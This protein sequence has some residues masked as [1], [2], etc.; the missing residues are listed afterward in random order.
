MSDQQ[1]L[2]PT[3]TNFVDLLEYRATHTPNQTAY[4][5]L[6]EGETETARITYAELQQ[7]TQL[8]ATH[9]TTK[10]NPGDRALLLYSSG[11][12]FIITFFAC[13]RAYIIA[14]PIYPP[15]RNQSLTRLQ[16]IA[17][18]S[19]PTLALTTQKTLT[20]ITKNWETPPLD[21]DINWIATDHPA[22]LSGVEG[23]GDDHSRRLSGAE[24]FLQYTSGSTGTPKGV[25]VTHTN[26]IHNSRNIY[27][28]FNSHP[29]HIGVSWL[30]FHHDMGLIGGVLQS[31]YG[32][33]T[34]ILM[35]PVAFLQKP[36]RWLQAISH[37][38]ACTSG[39]PNFAYD[40][41]VQTA[42][43]E[44]IAQLDLSYWTLAFTGAE[45]IRPETLEKFT[46]TFSD[47]GFQRKTFYPCYGMA[48]TTL[49]VT[50]GNRTEEPITYTAN[51]SALESNKVVTST[52]KEKLSETKTLIGCGHTWLDQQVKIV[53]P[54]T[55][56]PCKPEEIGEI[57]VSGSSVTKGYWQKP[58][59]TKETFQAYLRDTKEGPYLRTGDL[60][61]LQSEELF[62]TGRLKDI[63][64][65]RGRNYYPQDIEL[66]VETAHE[67][68]QPNGCAAFSIEKN[69]TEQL[70]VIQEVKRPYLRK[71]SDKQ[72]KKEIILSIRRA[73]SEAHELQPHAIVLLKP[74]HLPKTSSGKV[75]RKQCKQDFIEEN[76]EAIALWER[77]LQSN[78]PEPNPTFAVDLNPLSPADRITAVETWLTQRIAQYA[79]LSPAEINRQEPLAS[80]GLSSLQVVEISTE[81]EA[82]LNQSILPTI[83]YDFPTIATL[84]QQLI[85][86][87]Q[88]P[89]AETTPEPQK[90]SPSK[91]TTEDEIAVVGIGCRFPGAPTVQAFWQLLQQGQDAITEI[92]LS[93]WDT[94]EVPVQNI[95][96]HGG[97]L[98][99]IDQFD[100]K[101]FGISPREATHMDPQQR[102]LLEVCWE[103]LENAGI[104]AD[105]LEGSQSGI[106]LGISNGDYSRLQAT[107]LNTEV[108]YGTGNA[109][110][111]TANR[112]S[113]FFNWHGPSYA[114]D[115]ACS[116]S[117]VA[118]HQACNSL[119]QKE[120]N[121]ALAG[122]I[123]LILSPQLTVTFSQAQMMA[124]DGRCKTFDANADGYVRSE[125]CGII[126]LKRLSDALADNNHILGVIK[127]S[128]INQDGRSNGLTAPNGVAQQTVIRQALAN[129]NISAEQIDYIE[130]HGTGTALGDPIEVNALK[131]VFSQKRG[132][133]IPHWLGSVKTNIG[134]LES[135]AGIAGV[136][137]VLLS[138]QNEVIPPH[139]HL[140]KVNPYIQI[141]NLPLSIPTKQQAWK[142]ST[143]PRLAGVSSFGFGGT[144]AHIIISDRPNRTVQ[145]FNTKKPQPTH[146]F[147]LSANSEQ[148]L[149]ELVSRYQD[150]LESNSHIPIEEIC[151]GVNVGRSHLTH[152]LAITTPSTQQLQTQLQTLSNNPTVIK[153]K[154]PN[155]KPPKIAFLFTGQGS[156]YFSM[157]KELYNT[158]PTFRKTLSRCAEILTQYNINLLEVLYQQNNNQLNQTAY[159]QPVL[160]VLEYALAKLWQSWGIKPD[161]VLGH[162]VG[163][164]AAACIA[165]VF[166]LEEG[167]K[168]IAERGRLMQALPTG[169]KMLSLLATQTQAQTII[170]PYKES[171]S[172]AAINGPESIVISGEGKA[173]SEIIPQL[174]QQQIKHKK[175]TVSHAFHS[176]LMSPIV[177]D[178]A[179]LANSIT[180]Q[181]SSIPFISCLTGE[182]IA[183]K[184]ATANY[185]I[186]HIQQPVQFAP[187]VQTLH[188]KEAHIL[189]EVGPKPLLLGMAKQCQPEANVQYLPSLRPNQRDWQQLLTTLSHLYIQG[190][191][192]N[193]K[194][195][196]PNQI[197]K[198][199]L[200]P[201]YPF[202]RRRYWIEPSTPSTHQPHSQI[203]QTVASKNSPAST[204]KHLS[205]TALYPSRHPLL[206]Q[207]LSSPLIQFQSQISAHFPNYLT[208]HKVFSQT[209]FPA[210]AYLEIALTA[211]ASQNEVNTSLTLSDVNI[212]RGLILPE[213]L[214]EE[215]EITL[216]TILTPKENKTYQFQIFSLEQT[217]AQ[218][219]AQWIEHTT[220]IVKTTELAT[221]TPVD[222]ESYKSNF[223]EVVPVESFYRKLRDRTLEYGPTFQTI[224][225]LWRAPHQ[226]LAQITLSK[227][228]EADSSEPETYQIHPTLLDGCFQILAAAIDNTETQYIYL[229][230]G[231]EQL[232]L[233]APIPSQV[234]AI[235]TLLQPKDSST[236]QLLGNI[237]ITDSAGNLLAEVKGLILKQTNKDLLLRILQPAAPPTLYT[238]SWEKSPLR[239]QPAPI[240]SENWL[241]FLPQQPISQTLTAALQAQGHNCIQVHRSD[242]YQQIDNQHYQL[243][244][245]QPADYQQLIQSLANTIIKG[246]V[247]LQSIAT[248]NPSQEVLYLTQALIQS[249]TTT[250]LW[251][252]TRGVQLIESNSNPIQLSTIQQSTLHGL[253]RVIN[254][255]HPE[256]NCRSLDLDPNA[257]D[258]Q[259]LI[260]E[261]LSPDTENQ[262][263]HRNSDRYIAHLT[264]YHP[265]TQTNLLPIPRSSSFQL[266][267]KEYGLIDNLTLQPTQRRSPGP[268]DV[269][270]QV[271]AAGLNFRDV[272]NVLGLLKDYYAQNLGIT[273]ANQLTFGFECAGT[274]VSK[275]SQVSHL[276]IGDEVIATMLTDGVSR[277]VTTRSEFVIPKPTHIS[278]AEA[279]TL[280]LAFLT[281]YYGLHHLTQ[282]KPG[283]KI[284]IHAAAGGVGQ[285]AVQIA[286]KAGAEIFATASPSKWDFLKKQGISH[287]MN[288][289]TLAFAEEIKQA[290]NNKGVDVILNSLNGEYIAKSFE[291]LAENGRFIELGKIG[292]WKRSKVQETYP[293]AHYYPFDLGEV[294]KENPAIIHNLWTKLSTHFNQQH[295]QSLPSKSF[296]VQQSTQAFR[297]IQQA[298]HIGKVVL[299]LPVSSSQNIISPTSNYLVTGGLGAL[300]LQIAQWLTNQ[301]AQQVTLVGR[302]N[303]SPAAETKIAQM[304]AAGTNIV[305]LK[306]DISKERVVA[307]IIQQLKTETHLPLK[308]LIHTAGVLEDGLLSQLSWTQFENVMAPKARGTWHLHQHTQSLS[309]DFFVCFSSIASLIGSPGQAN[310]AAANTF[311]DTLMQHRR[312]S[313]LPGLSI[314]WGPWSNAGMAAQL[315]STTQK[316]MR[317]RG[318]N[319]IDPEA[320]L[321]I[322]KDLLTTSITN[323]STDTPAQVGAF[324]INWNKFIAQLPSRVSLPLLKQLKEQ[325]QTDNSSLQSD[326]LQGLEQLKQLPVAERRQRLMHQIQAEIADVLGYNDPKEIA[327]DQP[328][329]DLGVDSLMA[330]ELANQLEHNLGPTIPASFLFEHPTLQGLVNYL[331]EQ[332]S[333]VE[334]D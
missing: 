52:R 22:T 307:D 271:A 109:F 170:E 175:L 35:P 173:I 185:W 259:Q 314:N 253:S 283:D 247:Y 297:Y 301:G 325:I 37:Y 132:N 248:S 6:E 316:R 62:I 151:F 157:G 8:L 264:H 298:K 9:L 57:W 150:F 141:E 255:E 179:A 153:G 58:K 251:L 20:D 286:Q 209:I 56:L 169:G 11:L 212:Q 55:F 161:T 303:P 231:I 309:L 195:L 184:I 43:P 10:A 128:A 127:G 140:K 191:K 287:I 155:H 268:H 133:D 130:A 80:Y 324:S 160:F 320:A 120:C 48:E 106:F 15:R 124:A 250:S 97:F 108:Y 102:L 226:A 192:I 216:Q 85:L 315:D 269:E 30:P 1:T 318:I 224:T 61:F 284:L 39:G 241:L 229:P 147:T 63:I 198:G 223:L 181:T 330:V 105:Q 182:P 332:L 188:Q 110:S 230:S 54:E 322:L 12:D 245:T 41:C 219:E 289:R 200:L 5:F 240:L 266:K 242:Q 13:L 329:G 19:Q 328:L 143:T 126:A 300:G 131:N 172:I 88:K 96:R 163:E 295:F 64:I 334:F 186:E 333:E 81:L 122:G 180:Y 159:T 272:L 18:D 215:T 206:G 70:V 207:K 94:D 190:I 265:T 197:N 291:V 45:P 49:L 33:G 17:Q 249:R 201:T 90:R 193:W 321:K 281:A 246:V 227:S 168:L 282:L 243:N 115:T 238:L 323:P 104:A 26:L 139:L 79:Q 165:N 164:Y 91:K 237:Q 98:K 118:I 196:H 211:G 27:T 14:V 24:A 123:N 277:F 222:L 158:Q 87:K 171:V 167:L 51:R 113:Y 274:V 114:I 244:P 144:N 82:W 76:V 290:T 254:L 3:I 261:L 83:I 270:I 162:S 137:K 65:I 117:L 187:A 331:V 313:G 156:Q 154:V 267:L 208:D 205:S 174:Q 258:I 217:T 73:I 135:A 66:T 234:W 125:G 44:Q 279:A 166:S 75:Q 288:S 317:S 100:P 38:K 178:F 252:I 311:M 213:E 93:R 67:A 69:A 176:P 68:L 285:A 220:G 42:K 36:I 299:T 29:D 280:P 145:F 306:G 294:T 214:P 257:T 256:L 149:T 60:G 89:E 148:A 221:P 146:L 327:L 138:L 101:F 292:I 326:H 260:Q 203:H 119:R 152:R 236:H 111:I 74:G 121:F 2:D 116:S 53:N 304:R 59:Q 72:L 99:Q 235:G 40:L 50:G 84:S 262:I 71:L 4:I 239:S 293:T 276:Q 218:K 232:T 228:L 189:L 78:T 23:F 275:G 31:L 16:S 308:G 25:I 204:Q 129:A 112:L 233:Y 46:Q 194:N 92:P 34:V 273:H 134:H 319:P 310:Y 199:I 107:Q 263:A 103:T 302:N 177:E 86:S 183:E 77:T 142:P 305:V 296:P 32:G 278:F 95:A 136:I 202:Q 21:P 28:C 312:K 7:Q 210:A 47:C 225:Q